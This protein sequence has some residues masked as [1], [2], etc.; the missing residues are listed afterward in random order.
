MRPSN[1]VEARLLAELTSSDSAPDPS[2]HAQ[3]PS[4]GSEESADSGGSPGGPTKRTTNAPPALNLIPPV[5]IPPDFPSMDEVL[6][7]TS[8]SNL[9]PDKVRE[10]WS[11]FTRCAVEMVESFQSAKYEKVTSKLY[12]SLHSDNSDVFVTSSSLLFVLSTKTHWPN[13]KLASFWLIL[14]FL[15]WN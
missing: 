2:G 5:M 3:Q 11:A 1:L 8:A 14:R 15:V 13:R 9:D 7:T 6:H 10:M 4:Q 12:A